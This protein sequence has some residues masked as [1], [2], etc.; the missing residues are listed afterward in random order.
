MASLKGCDRTVMDVA[1]SGEVGSVLNIVGAGT[2]T[3]L[4]RIAVEQSGTHIPL[5]ISLDGIHGFRTIFP[6]PLA[7]ARSWDPTAAER[8][9]RVA[10]GEAAANG[11]D[12]TFA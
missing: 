2:V 4:Q 1:V 3:R 11:I 12:W 7:E 8:S 6:V 5:L 9:A 10:A